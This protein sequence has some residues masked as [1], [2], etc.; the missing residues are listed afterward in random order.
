MLRRVT[1][2][3]GHLQKKTAPDARLFGVHSQLVFTSDA[4]TTMAWKQV[5]P[6]RWRA[7]WRALT[8]HDGGL[9]R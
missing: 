2:P 9:Q 5:V 1:K 6:M 7:P 3:S 8:T 4:W